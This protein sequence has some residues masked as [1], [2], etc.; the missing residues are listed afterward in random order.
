MNSFYTEEELQKIGFK[1][2][3]TNVLISR[4]AKFYYMNHKTKVCSNKGYL[5]PY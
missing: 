3:G 1:S 2:F 4:N 5:F